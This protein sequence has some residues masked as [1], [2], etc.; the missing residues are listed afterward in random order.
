MSIPRVT[1]VARQS[2]A[3]KHLK[4]EKADPCTVVILGAGGDLMHRKLMPAL[5]YLAAQH[6]LP[7]D[8]ALLGVGRDPMDHDAFA[9][10]MREALEH[11][12]EV[13]AVDNETWDWLSRRI[14]YAYGDLSGNEV[15]EAIRR[16]LDE[17]ERPLPERDR[18]RLFY[19]AIPPSVFETTVEHLSSSGLAPHT[20]PDDVHPWA[21]VVIEKPFGR[22]LKSAHELNRIVLDRFDEHQI[23]RIDHY[24]GKESVQNILVFRFANPIFEPLWSRQ[25]IKSVQITVAET[26]GIDTRGKYYEEAGVIRDMFQNHLLQLLALAAM[27]PPI[28][29][30]GH[31]VRDEKVKVLRAARPLVGQGDVPVVLGQYAAAEV[32]GEH[33]VGY[34]EEKNVDPKSITPTFAAI[35]FSIDNWRWKHVPFYLR[36]GKRMAERKSEIAITFRS[37]PVLMFGQDELESMCPSTLIMRVQPDEGIS[38]RFQVKTPG[39]H[40][41][42]TSNLEISPVDMEFSYAEAFGAETPPAYQTLLLDCMI[43]DQT[44]FTR[45]DEVE[46]AWDIIDPLLKHLER[47]PPHDLPAYPAGSWG[48]AQADELLRGA[49]SRW[50]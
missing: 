21:R 46:A 42:L 30:N 7:D 26:V 18:N 16:R 45:S 35:R 8:F 12:D 24:L 31:E 9:T 23:Y 15:Y 49:H 5:Y 11:S 4:R 32:G 39:A 44:L 37:P 6:L 2:V 27:E 1:P 13:K 19:L 41:E 48:P 38:L 22:D 28:A 36:S 14:F 50:R 10:S 34:R 40:N 20:R 3:T 17:I 29:F 33:V 47:R 43:G 25:Y